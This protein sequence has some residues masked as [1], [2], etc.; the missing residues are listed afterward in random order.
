M[1]ADVSWV[2]FYS[3]AIASHLAWAIAFWSWLPICALPIT[4]ASYLV[5]I[6]IEVFPW[7]IL[8]RLHVRVLTR[9]FLLAGEGDGR[10][11]RIGTSVHGLQEE[12]TMEADSVH[13]VKKIRMRLE[14]VI[15][16]CLWGWSHPLSSF[17]VS[18]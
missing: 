10:R 14:R 18:P 1:V 4:V 12:S 3:A 16:S 13:M 15:D 2:S 6:P 17:V 5:K 8:E 11:S 7:F 9:N